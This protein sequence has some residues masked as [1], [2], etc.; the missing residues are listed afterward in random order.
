MKVQV[1]LGCRDGSAE[2]HYSRD[3]SGGILIEGQGTKVTVLEVPTLPAAPTREDFAAWAK[4]NIN[5]AWQSAGIGQDGWKGGTVYA[6]ALEFPVVVRQYHEVNHFMPSGDPE[7]S[8]HTLQPG[9][10]IECDVVSSNV[11]TL[12][13]VKPV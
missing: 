6:K 12:L 5:H 10:E 8:D 7:Y 4:D 13:V 11:V 3:K 1:E 9:Q 2:L